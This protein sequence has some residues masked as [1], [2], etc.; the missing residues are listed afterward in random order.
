MSLQGVQDVSV[1]WLYGGC[2]EDSQVRG[3]VHGS[4]DPGICQCSFATTL[5][6]PFT[7]HTLLRPVS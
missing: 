7:G 3:V 6:L 1:W 4:A 5:T 2:D